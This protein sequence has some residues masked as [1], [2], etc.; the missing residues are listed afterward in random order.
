MFITVLFYGL[1][2]APLARR[3][4]LIQLNPQGILFV[5]ADAWVRAL[6]QVLHEESI[7]VFLVDTDRENI[8]LTRMAGLPCLYGSALAEVTRERIDYAGLGRLLAVTPNNEVNSLACMYYTEDFGRQELYQLPFP[9]RKEGVHEVLAS[10][11]HG[12]LL[13]SKELTFEQLHEMTFSDS[14]IKK[15]K[16]TKEFD[17]TNYRNEYG[18]SAFPLVF[19]KCDRSIQICTISATVDPHPGDTVIS[20]VRSSN[21]RQVES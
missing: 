21:V 12:R 15:T 5:G 4:G 8:N 19:I 11:N 18:G 16:L 17:F 14:K 2:A 7:A 10:E 3:L 1:S 6:A 20:I 9:P 13:F